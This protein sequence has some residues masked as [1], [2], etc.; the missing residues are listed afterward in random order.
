MFLS[1]PENQFLPS[2]PSEGYDADDSH[3]SEDVLHLRKPGAHF[4]AVQHS[5]SKMFMVSLLRLMLILE[6]S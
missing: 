2:L 5:R 1:A 4:I 3:M 6:I